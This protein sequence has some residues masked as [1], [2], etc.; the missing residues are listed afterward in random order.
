[1]S[2]SWWNIFSQ[3]GMSFGKL[4]SDPVGM[5]LRS[6]RVASLHWWIKRRIRGA[7]VTLRC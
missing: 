4:L 2:W 7:L 3:S 5:F 1:M 6:K